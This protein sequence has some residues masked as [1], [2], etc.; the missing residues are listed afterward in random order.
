MKAKKNMS[1]DFLETYN[2]IRKPV[3]KPTKCHNN[4]K[5]EYVRKWDYRRELDKE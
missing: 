2:S 5:N 1:K 3:T 4:P